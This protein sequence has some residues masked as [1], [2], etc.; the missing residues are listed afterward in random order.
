MLVRGKHVGPGSDPRSTPRRMAL[1]TL[2]CMA[3]GL[4]SGIRS[5]VSHLE[6]G[7]GSPIWN[8]VQGHFRVLGSSE[9]QTPLAAWITRFSSDSESPT[10]E[11]ERIK[12]GGTGGKIRAVRTARSHS[13]LI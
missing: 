13:T 5:R 7:P 10:P 12:E 1:H 11:K 6:S 8:Q 2:Q 9:L 4:S 3:Q